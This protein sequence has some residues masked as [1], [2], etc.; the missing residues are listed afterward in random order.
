LPLAPL[1]ITKKL[2]GFE[3]QLPNLKQ[4]QSRLQF[5]SLLIPLLFLSAPTTVQGQI[6]AEIIT[7]DAAF[8]E[9]GEISIDIKF[10]ESFN[11][12]FDAWIR[13]SDSEGVFKEAWRIENLYPSENDGSY[14]FSTQ[15]T[16]DASIDSYGY[17]DFLISIEKAID[18][19]NNEY[20][21]DDIAG[22][23]TVSLFQTPTP[24]IVDDAT[25]VCGLSKQLNATPGAESNTYYWEAVTGASFSDA[26]LTDPL[27]TA[28]ED[29]I[30]ELTFT[31]TNGPCSASDVV[32][33]TLWGEPSGSLST[34]SEICGTGEA[35][36]HFNLQGYGPWTV[37]YSFGGE[38]EQLATSNNTPTQTHSLS[39]ESIFQLQSVTDVH[40]CSTTYT[41]EPGTT[42]T[43]IDLLPVANAGNDRAVCGNEIS[44]SA[45]EPSIGTGTW[46]GGGSFSDIHDKNSLFNPDPFT[47]EVSKTLIWTVKNKECTVSDQIAVTFYEQLEA[48]DISAGK[49]TLLYQQNSFI[50]EAAPLPFG[51]GTW[52]ILSGNGQITQA[53][54]PQAEISQLDYGQTLLRWTVSNGECAPVWQEVGIRV[55]SIQHPTGFSPNGDGLNDVLELPGAKTIEN[56]QLI[57][58]NRQGT[59]VYKINNYQNDWKGTKQNGEA[60]PDG[61]YYY[62][63]TGD[64]V[65]IKDYLI[66]KRSKR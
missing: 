2:L 65:N 9:S 60:L 22:T 56:N 63:F 12:P 26:S 50:L 41:D 14:T 20:S 36:I 49:D 45:A 19:S 46:S 44:L 34:E 38:A 8:C 40:G 58:F 21:G 59:V 33:V 55:Q 16:F 47:G 31:Q 6:M 25:P 62:V 3:G 42:A 17:G 66:L 52:T 43:V 15:K 13:I 1:R 30:Y 29:G 7:P 64:G 53:N 35:E 4:M 48:T 10:G 39:G 54:N 61:Y 18:G 27:F 51:V 57:V 5:L 11:A 24:Q 28:D 23:T 32:S 37:N